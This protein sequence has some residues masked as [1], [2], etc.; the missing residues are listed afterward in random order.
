M[1]ISKNSKVGSDSVWSFP[2]NPQTTAENILAKISAIG[3]EQIN[4]VIIKIEIEPLPKVSQLLWL[5]AYIWRKLLRNFREM[6][7]FSP[8]CIVCKSSPN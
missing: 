7:Q 3:G 6:N 5:T 1:Y 8:A 2:Q 4:L